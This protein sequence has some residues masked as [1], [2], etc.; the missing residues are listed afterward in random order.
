MHAAIDSIHKKRPLGAGGKLVSL[1]DLGYTDVGVD[2]GW[3]R[4]EGV[5]GSYHD[6]KGQV[7]VNLTKFPS[8]AKMNE[9]AHAN[10]L[11]SSWYLNCDQCPM[12]NV[13]ESVVTDAWYTN[14]AKQAAL[15]NF[16]G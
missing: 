3:A 4:C 1:Q 13:T 10:G 9:H 12:T 11:T 5:N 15:L 2:G 8:F 16:D 14:D 7:L 6:E